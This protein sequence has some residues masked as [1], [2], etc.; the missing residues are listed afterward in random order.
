[1]AS[2]VVFRYW[3]GKPDMDSATVPRQSSS[4]ADG[5]YRFNWFLSLRRKR[6][7]PPQP[8]SIQK[9]E[10]V[11]GTGTGA[12]R[13]DDLF[14]AE[15]GVHHQN[16]GSVFYTLRKRFQKKF[17]SVKVKAYEPDVSSGESST[18]AHSSN[19]GNNSNPPLRDSDAEFAR[20]VIERH[21]QN[22]IRFSSPNANLPVIMNRDTVPNT[23]AVEGSD[24]AGDPSARVD[25][26]QVE[27]VGEE[28]ECRP[29]LDEMME[30]MRID[31]L[32][33]GWYWGKLT[34]SA[35]QK[36]LARQVNGT[37]LV[38]DSQTEKYQFTVSFRSSGITLHCRIDFKNNYWSFSGLTTPST[39][40]TMIELVED[41]MKK[42]EFGVIGYVKQNSPLMP[43]F[44][45]RLTKPINRFYEVSTLQHL[46]RFI[47]RQ[48]IDP[49]DIAMLPLPV[50]LKQ[51]VEENFYDL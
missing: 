30:R 7:S 36:R 6:S 11:V 24:S 31:L 43:P 14:T 46:C 37:F 19:T 50:K 48:K 49:K 15:G 23:G 25:T 2:L 21:T 41:T 4:P 13:K 16:H 5:V 12:R 17:T 29:S 3:P 42:S 18:N 45:V 39:Y 38:R 51:Y 26:Q 35:A 9:N 8:S 47:I 40:A 10:G 44:P 28:D 22:P 1:M 20:I 33:Y 27:G 32:Q 34:R